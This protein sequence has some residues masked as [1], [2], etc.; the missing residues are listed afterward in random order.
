MIEPMSSVDEWR[1][2][3]F[4]PLTSATRFFRSSASALRLRN[5]TSVS[6]RSA[7]MLVKRQ[8]RLD[9]IALIRL[10]KTVVISDSASSK[11]FGT[12]KK[13][14]NFHREIID[15]CRSRQ[16]EVEYSFSWQTQTWGPCFVRVEICLDKSFSNFPKLRGPLDVVAAL[17]VGGLVATSFTGFSLFS[18]SAVVLESPSPR[19]LLSP[20]CCCCFDC[21]C[22]KEV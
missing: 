17:S 8:S 5:N 20:R 3:R 16:D 2:C 11:L 21:S 12:Y 14:R 1:L 4:N 7:L 13:K 6:T 18:F 19:S 22:S 9:R 15:C 10:S